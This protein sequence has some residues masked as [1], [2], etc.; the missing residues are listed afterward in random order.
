MNTAIQ[1]MY[2]WN[3]LPCKEI[4]KGVLPFQKRMYQALP[5]HGWCS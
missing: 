2:R 3:R 1:P 5:R 4:E